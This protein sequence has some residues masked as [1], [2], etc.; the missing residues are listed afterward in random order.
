MGLQFCVGS[1]ADVFEEEYASLVASK[2]QLETAAGE[3]YYSS[4]LGWSGWEL[5]QERALE[6]LDEDGIPNLLAMPAW[7]GCY[8]PNA[9]TVSSVEVD[10]DD[11]PLAVA[12]LTGLQRELK[13]LAEVWQK[14][15]DQETLRKLA[16]HYNEDEYVD[17]DMDVQTYVQLSLAADE[18]L[19]RQAV[20]WVVK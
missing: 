13:A 7:K 2:L 20:L 15:T 11:D 5:L 14:P 19:R 1:P 9:T 4:E 8:L 18:A 10:G 16:A 6:L 17:D 12:S 3:P